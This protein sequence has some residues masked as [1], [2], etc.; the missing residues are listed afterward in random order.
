VRELENA[1]ERALILSKGG[2]L[3]FD[4]LLTSWG[5]DFLP[6]EADGQ[7]L[8]KLD[9]VLSL[10]IRRILE[11]TGGKVHGDDGAATLLGMNSSTLRSKMRKMGITFGR[12][13]KGP[14]TK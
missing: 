13:A 2:S 14:G 10:H 12:K 11:R 5:V 4:P 8:I 7:E 9:S 1:V 3:A 6:A